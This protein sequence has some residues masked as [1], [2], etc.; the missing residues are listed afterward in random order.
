MVSG[1]A[2]DLV[3]FRNFIGDSDLGSWRGPW[4]VGFGEVFHHVL[5]I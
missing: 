5:I 1:C 2:A 3:S 4:A